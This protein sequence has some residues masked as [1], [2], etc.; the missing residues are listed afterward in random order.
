MTI[1]LWK[2]NLEEKSSWAQSVIRAGSHSDIFKIYTIFSTK[3][4]PNNSTNLTI[5]TTRKY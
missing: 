3:I 5:K 4:L 1:L 2:V